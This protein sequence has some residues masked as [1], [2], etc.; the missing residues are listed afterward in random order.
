MYF[1][2]DEA[3]KVVIGWS[4][5]CGCTHIKRVY[6]DMINHPA[7][8][9]KFVH[10]L[11]PYARLPKLI[12]NY[13]V[14]IVTRS[15]YERLVSGFIDKYAPNGECR[16][17]W[18]D[19]L[20]LSFENFVYKLGAPCVE[21][22]HF[23]PQCAESYDPRVSRG[24]TF[25]SMDISALDYKYLARI[26]GAKEYEYSQISRGSHTRQQTLHMENAHRIEYN[27]D[28]H[29]MLSSA[30]WES[31]YDTSLYQHVATWY[32][33]DFHDANIGQNPSRGSQICASVMCGRTASFENL[34]VLHCFAGFDV[35]TIDLSAMQKIEVLLLH[36]LGLRSLPPL[37]F[38]L[39]R[40]L[41]LDNNRLESLSADIG[42][43][44]SL[45]EL[46]LNKN[47]LISLPE[48]IGSCENLRALCLRANRLRRLPN[49]L[50]SCVE[51]RLLDVRDNPQL[52]PLPAS[53]KF[54]KA[55]ELLFG[56]KPQIPPILLLKWK[57]GN[58]ITK[59]AFVYHTLLNQC[60]LYL[61][62][63]PRVQE[64]PRNILVSECDS[65]ALY[66]STC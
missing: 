21:H 24:R 3:R 23:A 1:I 30:S 62:K 51:L 55:L 61:C 16:F 58:F 56:Q 66:D 64:T 41:D 49:E 8:K 65:I 4:P 12:E 32:A 2:V 26:L 6:L 35:A 59:L 39:L 5:K 9:L 11:W 50:G 27:S 38:M 54:S 53:I 13:D 28:S 31:F 10:G 45:R 19:T 46:R 7:A 18:P 20:P 57:L 25:K 34:R 60:C 22:H 15:P 37:R 52:S 42:K 36:S 63:R 43:L 17:M 29:K 44:P 14:V 47:R 33:S 40:K 48:E